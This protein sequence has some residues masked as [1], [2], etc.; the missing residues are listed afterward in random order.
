M[1]ISKTISVIPKT[2]GSFLGLI[3]DSEKPHTSESML[4]V[5]EVNN[6]KYTIGKFILCVY[7]SIL[8]KLVKMFLE[9]RGVKKI[10]LIFI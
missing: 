5:R 9:K 10:K 1:H 3:R 7:F 6:K 8:Q 2:M 4:T